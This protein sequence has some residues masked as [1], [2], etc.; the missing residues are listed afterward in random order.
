VRVYA[1]RA[2]RLA[3]EIL[4][5]VTSRVTGPRPT[6]RKRSCGFLAAAA[7]GLALAGAASATPAIAAGRPS[8]PASKVNVPLAHAAS[9]AHARHSRRKNKR[10]HHAVVAGAARPAAGVVAP[11]GP[12]P[13]WGNETI[14]DCTFAS[15]ADWALITQGKTAVTDAQVIQEFHEA[16]GSD[17]EG[18]ST[19]ELASTWSSHGIAGVHARLTE[20]PASALES[21]VRPGTAALAVLAI[22]TGQRFV[23]VRYKLHGHAMTGQPFR[24][25]EGGDHTLV[26]AGYNS[27]GPQVVTWGSTIQMTWTQWT[28]DHPKLYE[29]SCTGVCRARAAVDH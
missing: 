24:V 21:V 8:F 18:L 23:P 15:A 27:T 10:H 25:A 13:E 2:E 29:V 17:S 12:W 20:R 22:P 19:P 26:V 9:P 14:G 4:S 5:M 1:A 11:T 7:S 28:E 16:H 6:I 3:V